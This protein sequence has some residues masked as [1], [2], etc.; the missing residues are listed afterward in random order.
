VVLTKSD[1]LRGA[2]REALVTE[3]EAA[4]K[5]HPSAFPRV[6]LTSAETKE[7]VPELRA[8]LAGFAV[9]LGV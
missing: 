7:G 1:K 6:L 8:M 4:L 3:T 2:D 5:R 9:P